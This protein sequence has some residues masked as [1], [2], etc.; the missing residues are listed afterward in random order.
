MNPT[1]ITLVGVAQATLQVWLGQAQQA[2]QNLSTGQL[3]QTVSY[4]Q[5]EGN[6]SVT[7]SRTD[8]AKLREWIGEI[9]QALN[10][11]DSRFTRRPIRVRF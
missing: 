7:Y 1:P 3:V 5:G 10:P 11:S 6:R 8:I 2:L 4:A 9:Q